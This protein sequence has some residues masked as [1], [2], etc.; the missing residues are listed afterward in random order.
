MSRALTFLPQR[1][2][3]GESLAESRLALLDFPQR[4]L[5]CASLAEFHRE[6]PTLS[7]GVAS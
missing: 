6:A 2:L 4:N 3:I 7:G 1:N 5:I